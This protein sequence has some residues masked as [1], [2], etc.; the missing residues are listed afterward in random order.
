MERVPE[1]EYN[2]RL[3][4]IR[5][6]GFNDTDAVIQQVDEDGRDG[7]PRRP[8][9]SPVELLA[10]EEGQGR[11]LAQEQMPVYNAVCFRP[12]ANQCAVTPVSL[13]WHDTCPAVTMHLVLS[14]M[15]IRPLLKQAHV[16]PAAGVKTAFNSQYCRDS[17]SVEEGVTHSKQMD[18]PRRNLSKR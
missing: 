4:W 2:G 8:R 11:K 7:E 6:P 12:R 1:T 17:A 16:W 10:K 9:P 3:L 18:M 14:R 5:D 15:T 13:H